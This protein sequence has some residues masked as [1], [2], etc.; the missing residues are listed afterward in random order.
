MITA[1][2]EASWRHLGEYP[3]LKLLFNIDLYGMSIGRK[4]I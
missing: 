3:H 4:R 1:G 2:L